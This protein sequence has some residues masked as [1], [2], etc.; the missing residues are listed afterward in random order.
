MTVGGLASPLASKTPARRLSRP[1][2]VASLVLRNRAQATVLR[3]SVTTV[4]DS[5]V[6]VELD[7]ASE[8]GGERLPAHCRAGKDGGAATYTAAYLSSSLTSSGMGFLDVDGFDRIPFCV[9]SG[10]DAGASWV[11]SQGRFRLIALATENWDWRSAAPKPTS[12]RA[13]EAEIDRGSLRV[14]LRPQTVMELRRS[15]QL[16]AL[17]EAAEGDD[18]DTLRA[19]VTKARMACV[20][21]PHIER[22]LTR[23]RELRATGKH[24]GHGCAKAALAEKMQWDLVTSRQGESDQVEYCPACNDCPC[25]DLIRPGEILVIN[26]GEVQQCLQKYGPDPDVQ[27]F[28]QLVGA[29]LSV[30]EGC[31]WKAGGKLIFSEFNRNQSVTALSRMLIK[32]GRQRCANMIT[33]LLSHSETTYQGYVTAIQV[34]FHPHGSTYHDQ[35][36]DIYSAKQTAGPNCTCQFQDCVGTVC[37]SLGSSRLVHLET[38]T[39][40]TSALDPCGEACNGS[41]ERRWLHSGSGMYFNGDWNSNHTHGIPAMEE[42]C[43]PRIS[44]AFLLAARPPA[45][46]IK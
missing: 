34:N 13:V 25:N 40:A 17:Q 46:F 3:V 1:H 7:G 6:R 19:Q 8:A 43:G 33:D 29:A 9:R 24:V 12:G 37:Y 18:Y 27:L 20:E 30:E 16:Q 11:G 45:C 39:D 41:R 21:L 36:R 14:S 32:H 44:L 22:G 23:L 38:M 2:S 31:V 35:H 15:S 42:G 26:E 5:A 10:I 4:F 28:E